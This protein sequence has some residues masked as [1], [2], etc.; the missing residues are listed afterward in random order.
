[1]TWG[2]HGFRKINI[3]VPQKIL[4][5]NYLEAEAEMCRRIYDVSYSGW[6]LFGGKDD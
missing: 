6:I 1:M 5:S 4:Q 3:K 2:L